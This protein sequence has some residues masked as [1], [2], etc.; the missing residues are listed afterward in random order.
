MNYTFGILQAILRALADGTPSKP[1]I[2]ATRASITRPTANIYLAKLVSE[3]KL[4]KEGSGAHVTYRIVDTKYLPENTSNSK[5]ASHHFSYAQSTLLDEHFL[6]YDVDGQLLV[7]VEGFITWCEQR[8]LDPYTKY[9]NYA[10]CLKALTKMHTSCGV[11]DA[12]N[13]FIKHVDS[14]ALDMIYYADQY[15]LNEFG[16]SKLAEMGFLGKQLQ[17]LELLEQVIAQILRKLECVIK[18]SKVDALAFTPPTLKRKHQILDLLDTALTHIPLP[19][20]RLV[21]DYPTKI[22]TPQKSLKK[23]E[24]RVN[25]AKKSIYVYDPRVG[26]YA[27]VLLID[28]FVGSGATLNETAKKL[29]K[30]GVKKVIGF[31]IVGN[32]DMSYDIINEM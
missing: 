25:N 21:K 5:R 9:D 27:T 18:T 20:L 29:K 8:K 24:E 2:I 17:D 14:P 26:E 30:E 23:R 7:G 3:G 22:A 31:A 10:L 13:E 32:M 19:R 11:L 1:G 28:D 12:T 15:K 4:I 16:R 6:K